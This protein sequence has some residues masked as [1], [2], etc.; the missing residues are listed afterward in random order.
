M[1]GFNT[2]FLGIGS[3]WEDTTGLA[4]QVVSRAE[5][6]FESTPDEVLPAVEDFSLCRG[7][8]AHPVSIP[9]EMQR[10]IS[11]DTFYGSSAFYIFR[12]PE[13]SPRFRAGASMLFRDSSTMSLRL[14]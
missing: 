14:S 10:S 2:E 5:D 8:T 13:L 11:L 7:A 12:S 3:R 1:T 4:N 6:N 9:A